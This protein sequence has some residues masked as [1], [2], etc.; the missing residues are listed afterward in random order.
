[1]Q[2]K[3]IS[4]ASLVAAIPLGAFAQSSSVTLYGIVDT[5]VAIEDTGEPG[6]A[7]RTVLNS[8]NQ[9]SSRFGFRGSE[10]LGGGLKAVFNLESGFALDSGL[11]DSAFFGRRSVV[12]LEGSLGSLYMG[13]EY[14]PIAAVAAASDILG[15][16]FFGTNLSAFAGG[17]LSRRVSNAVTYRTPSVGGV[18]ASF[19]ASPREGDP[20]ARRVLGAA[21]EFA[22][23]RFYIGGGYHDLKGISGVKS[24]EYAV[25]LGYGFGA[26]EVK[27]NYLAADPMS[28]GN[29]F[30]QFNVGASVGLGSGRLFANAQHNRQ[31]GGAKGI[32]L[33]TAYSYPLSKRTNL[34]A[35]Y[36]RLSNN[37][38]GRFGLSSSSTSVTPAAFALGAGPSVFA[39]GLR[40]AF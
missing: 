33:A 31:E 8:G 9:S 38:K 27:G 7:S 39:V 17:R 28:E 2:K 6:R 36:A 4:I 22:A 23:G 14:S 25:G 24:K 16:G 1:M 19:V 10:D 20:D 21:V 15:Q 11:S 29:K 13:R 34:Y 30:E 18:K 3:W 5:A 35:S 32:A 40:H 26:F 12:G 37:A